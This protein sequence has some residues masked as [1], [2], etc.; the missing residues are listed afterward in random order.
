MVI[1]ALITAILSQTGRGDLV[2]PVI[3]V[4]AIVCGLIFAIKKKE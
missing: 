1:I 2:L 3:I 4:S